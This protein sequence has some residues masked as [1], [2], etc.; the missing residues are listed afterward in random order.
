MI[1]PVALINDTNTYHGRRPCM[2]APRNVARST[3]SKS[4]RAR[5]IQPMRI[6]CK[7]AESD[8]HFS[9]YL[10]SPLSWRKA[11]CMHAV[12]WKMLA[13][14]PAA[15]SVGRADGERRVRD[16]LSISAGDVFRG[17][18]LAVI[19]N[20]LASAT[21]EEILTFLQSSKNGS[22][23]VGH[24]CTRDKRRRWEDSPKVYRFKKV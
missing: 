12:L 17:R 7:T 5:P 6:N 10:N 21:G 19:R 18:M 20:A 4:L 9:R 1:F 16:I 15:L 2:H 14:K 24:R 13:T 3:K 11:F 23:S 8:Q 22:P